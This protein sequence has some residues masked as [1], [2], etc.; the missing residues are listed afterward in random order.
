MKKRLALAILA[1]ALCC[2]A[3]ASASIIRIGVSQG[4][5]NS[6]F[7]SV[8]D[9]TERALKERFGEEAVSFE[10]LPIREMEQSIREGRLDFFISTPGLARRMQE[11]GA[12]DFL[13]LST[14]RHPDPHRAFGAVFIV[15]KDSPVKSFADM[16]GARYATNRKGAFYGH[17]VAMGEVERRGLSP[18]SF[19]SSEAFLGW[20][21]EKV[22]R[23]VL[24]GD[25]DVGSVPSCYLEDAFPGKSPEEVGLRVVGVRE[26][27]PCISSTD[28]YPNWVIATLP[29]TSAAVS[30]D[31]AST[32]LAMKPGREGNAWNVAADNSSVDALYRRLQSGPYEFLRSW[33][34]GQLARRY[35]QWIAAALGVLAFLLANSLVM[36]KLVEERTAK[37]R[38]AMT[39][40]A[41]LQAEAA[42]SESRF[43][44]LQRVG[45]IGQMSSMIAHELR[46]PISSILAYSHGLS[47][48]V[49]TGDISRG[50]IQ[51]TL[52]KIHGQAEE[53][54]AIVER[55]RS[56]AKSPT[57]VKVKEPVGGVV[58]NALA[59][60][61][62]SGRFA[63]PVVFEERSPVESCVVPLEL[64]LAVLNL[65]RNAADSLKAAPVERPAIAVRLDREGDC[66]EI[67]VI[68]NGRKIS[69]ERLRQIE[70]P[71]S[72]TKEN[73]M[74]IG[75]SIVRSIAV[76]HGGRLLLAANPAGGLRAV[77]RL[78]LMESAD[79]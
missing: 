21:T 56:Y 23:A 78:P 6:D 3:Q 15:R 55:V 61:K 4:G 41:R 27:A 58:R 24:A 37:L 43:E 63:G 14:A 22:I 13:T 19:F 35:W 40:Q 66:Y 29:G 75:L 33:S 67:S 74:G 36:K 71:L 34:L 8:F 46:Q 51:E 28:L 72:S 11:Y 57:V 65:L 42:A 30:H 17:S 59:S 12:R 18:E 2:G 73:G 79:D 62:A 31:V 39:E 76:N 53:A 5:H 26:T 38:R 25:A 32:L 50:E 9:S 10:R 49:E 7:T 70:T 16:R 54:E 77:L 48:F 1:A 64:E 68:D 44:A 60:F 69:P 47:R 45:I 52:L 20:G